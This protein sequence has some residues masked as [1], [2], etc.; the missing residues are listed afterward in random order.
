MIDDKT[1]I[2]IGVPYVIT[3][4][5]RRMGKVMFSQVS[6][7]SHPVGWGGGWRG[8]VTHLHPII[9][10]LVACPFQWGTPSHNTSTG[11]MSFLGGPPMTDPR[12]LPGG[13]GVPQSWMAEGGTQGCGTPKP[14]MGYPLARSGHSPPPPPG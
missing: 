7:R 9:L 12:S 5:I 8:G 11:P 10:P 13:G 6:V 4:R 1:N 2:G 14:E 3:A